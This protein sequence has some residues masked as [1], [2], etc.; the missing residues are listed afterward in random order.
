P[1]LAAVAQDGPAAVM[2]EVDDV[3][4]E[5]RLVESGH[6]AKAGAQGRVLSQMPCLR[7]PGPPFPVGAAMATMGIA[8]KA[9]RP[10]P[11]PQGRRGYLTSASSCRRTGTSSRTWR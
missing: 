2:A 6:V 3:G 9:S 11:L 1:G 10:R 4:G 5:R 7:R 8:G